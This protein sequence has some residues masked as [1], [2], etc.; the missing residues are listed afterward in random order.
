MVLR[1][2]PTNAATIAASTVNA[3]TTPAMMVV[4]ETPGCGAALLVVGTGFGFVGRGVEVFG[5]GVFVAVEVA[6]AGSLRGV[7]V[8]FALVVFGAVVLVLVL[9][10][11]VLRG[12]VVGAVVLL[13]VVGAVVLLLV[14]GAAVCFAFTWNR[15]STRVVEPSA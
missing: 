1:I 7:V 14:L 11:V 3:D 12:V 8:D 6:G 5:A 9:G 4:C 13:V 10:A 2:S 15:T